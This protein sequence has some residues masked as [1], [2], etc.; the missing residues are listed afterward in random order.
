MVRAN[1]GSQLAKHS[2]DLLHGLKAE[3]GLDARVVVEGDPKIESLL[4]APNVGVRDAQKS[5]RPAFP[6]CPQLR[7]VDA[8]I[9]TT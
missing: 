7:L 8:K 6:E 5:F 1:P 2:R 4:I 3:Y 9:K